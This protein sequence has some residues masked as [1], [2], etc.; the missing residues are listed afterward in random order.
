[1]NT[2]DEMLSRCLADLETGRATIDEC[3]ARYPE[4]AAALR[5]LL[6]TALAVRSLPA[7]E[8]APE[9]LAAAQTRM[10]NLI[11]AR[12]RPA[13]QQRMPQAAP[14]PRRRWSGLLA[15]AA[16]AVVLASAM[17]GGTAYAARDTL[18]DSPLYPIKRT[19][20]QVQVAFA[21]SDVRRARVFVQLM[22]KRA[23]ETAAMIK[24]GKIERSREATVQYLRLLKDAEAIANRLPM[25]RPESRPLLLFLRD[26]LLAQQAGFQRLAAN[27]PERQQI[28]IRPV[29]SQIQ[30]TLDRINARLDGM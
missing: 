14:L 21:P 16:V 15:K 26:R 25:H 24:T 18:P 27:G 29:V 28:F 4:H 7:V 23:I 13:A 17:L 22:D 12:Q 8:P 30:R 6:R 19:V 1:M 3:L 10:Q 2:F 9:F 11:A 5:P 20:E